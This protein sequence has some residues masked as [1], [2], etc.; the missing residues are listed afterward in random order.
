[1][2]SKLLWPCNCNFCW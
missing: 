2:I 1:M